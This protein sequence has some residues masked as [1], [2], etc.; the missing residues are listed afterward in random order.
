MDRETGAVVVVVVVALEFSNEIP[1]IYR[2][3][4]MLL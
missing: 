1:V 3:S 2:Q 4:K